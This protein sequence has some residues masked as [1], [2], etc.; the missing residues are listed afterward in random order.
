MAW[1]YEDQDPNKKVLMALQ[2]AFEKCKNMVDIIF[3]VDGIFPFYDIIAE[4]MIE[5]HFEGRVAK[6]LVDGHY[7]SQFQ[8]FFSGTTRTEFS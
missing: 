5:N 7:G 4:H 3:H 6:P 2:Y 1:N 8:W